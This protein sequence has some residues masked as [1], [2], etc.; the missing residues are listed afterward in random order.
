MISSPNLLHQYFDPVRSPGLGEVDIKD[1][2][3]TDNDPALNLK[4]T[5]FTTGLTWY[6]QP[7]LP[8][9]QK[10]REKNGSL[11]DYGVQVKIKPDDP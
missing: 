5:N 2:R 7:A 11:L 4:S 1:I 6:I 3:D 9:L 8:N 10:A